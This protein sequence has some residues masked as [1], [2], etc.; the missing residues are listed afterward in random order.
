MAKAPKPT[1]IDAYISQFP[2][3]V[4]AA[5][6]EVREAIRRAAPDAEETISYQMAAFRQHG[7]LVYFAAWKQ[8][9]GL[10]PPISGDEA[11][12]KAV[13]GYAGPRPRPR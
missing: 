4:A 8:P 13:A 6:R 3:D 7:M 2:G 5:L 1:D 10:Y 9:I 11:I 12:E